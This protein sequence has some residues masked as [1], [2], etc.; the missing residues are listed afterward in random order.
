MIV[1]TGAAGFIGSCMVTKLN[2]MGHHQLILVDDFSRPEKKRNWENKQYSELVHRDDFFTYIEN[3]HH[4]VEVIIHLGARTNTAEL[5]YNLLEHLNLHYSQ[6]VWHYATKFSIPLV[7]ASSAATYGNGEW[8]Y[9]DDESQ[10]Y[11]LDPLNPYGR[12][13]HEFDKWVMQQGTT[14]PF[15]AGFKLF[16][17]FGP[18]E[19]HKGRMA[20]L[21]FHAFHQIEKTGNMNLFRSHHIEYKD[22]EQMSDFTYVKDVVNTIYWFLTHKPVSGIYNLGTG[23]ARSFYAL[24]SSVFKALKATENIN[25]VDIPEDIREKYQYFTEADMNKV[26]AA[27]FRK[28]FRSL[29][30]SVRDYVQQYLS[31]ERYF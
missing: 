30:L 9:R 19:Y 11:K 17:V 16:N 1:V 10:L 4:Q 13:K 23:F 22:G 14:P 31:K 24:A 28:P 25:F 15:W 12:S 6:K 5:D 8:G 3:N 27:Q 29:E 18:N 26:R 20:S 7:Y 2:S 21:V